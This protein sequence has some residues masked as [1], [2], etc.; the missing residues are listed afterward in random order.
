M[1]RGAQE[2]V[3]DGELR[4]EEQSLL[5]C[6]RLDAFLRESFIRGFA[7]AKGPPRLRLHVFRLRV[8][9]LWC[10]LIREMC[11]WEVLMGEVWWLLR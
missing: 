6:G 5:V 7:G 3:G 11:V 4:V 8:P 9:W 10:S 2:N 1:V